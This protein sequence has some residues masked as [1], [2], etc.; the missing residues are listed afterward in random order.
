MK[1]ILWLLLIAVALIIPS[2]SYA[3]IY[4]NSGTTPEDS[5]AF[6]F[7]FL[8]SLGQA[9]AGAADDSVYILVFYPGGEEA[10]RDSMVYTDANVVEELW[11]D[12]AGG[13]QY[14]LQYSVSEIDGSGLEGTYKVVVTA[15]DNS[16]TLNSSFHYEFQLYATNNYSTTLDF[17]VD[18][19]QGVIDSLQ[20]QDNWVAKEVSLLITSD[21][22]GINW[23]DITNQST[24]VNLSATTTNL[25]NTAT[26]VTNDVGITATAVDNIWDEDTTGHKT[27]PNM[28][29]WITQSVAGDISDADMISIIDTLLNKLVSDT[30][31]ATIMSKIVRD[32]SAAS[33][34]AIANN[35]DIGLVIDTVNGIMDTLQNQDDWVLQATVAGRT[36]DIAVTGTAGVDFDNIAGGLGAGEIDANAIGASELATTAV[37]EIWEY[38]SAN[39]S[40]AQA[41]GTMLKDTSAYQGSAAS[42]DTSQIKTLATNNPTLFYGPTAGGTGT[43]T[44]SFYVIDT[45]GTDTALSDVKVT[46][47]NSGGST[48]AV[49]I[50]DATGQ[51][52]LYLDAGTYTVIGKQSPAS[53]TM[54][55]FDSR[56]LTVSGNSTDSL[57]GY[58]LEI[59]SSSIP[60]LCRVYGY[61]FSSNGLAEIDAEVKASLPD[62]VVRTSGSII[63]PYGVTS[64][65]DSTGYFFL[66]LIPSDSLIPSSTK[67]EIS[68]SRPDG[69]ILR[70]RITVPDLSSWKLVW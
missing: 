67:Y 52:S 5:I 66:D 34:Q 39:V 22:I 7:Q 50:T 19:L 20:N 25:V 59:G 68:I 49:N 38:D 9:V 46:V 1:K 47:K 12:L 8:D 23:G 21:N 30:A 13:D 4:N 26:A 16:L 51:I 37:D 17:L 31:A 65:T 41:M 61:L 6:T 24:S 57:F 40:G 2:N 18:S 11:E 55:L 58:D 28:G 54:H 45:T 62:G 10:F 60:G 70:K 48:V 69:S 29:Y 43:D 3:G 64:T 14:S 36:L 42:L 15:N 63:S 35:T 56:S 44:L 32:A 53:P 27:D 33:A